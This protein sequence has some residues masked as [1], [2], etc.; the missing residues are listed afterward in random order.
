MFHPVSLFIGLRYTRAKRRNHFISFMSFTSMIGIALGVAVLITVLS[1]MN[2]FD[3]E[4]RERIFGMARQVT[5]SAYSGNLTHWQELQTTVTHY[6]GVLYEAPFVQSQGML[7]EGGLVRPVLIYGIQPSQEKNMSILADKFVA[8]NLEVLQPGKFGIVIGQKIADSLGLQV[9]DKVNLVT[10]SVSVTPMGVAPRFKRFTVVGVFKIGNGFDFDS[11]LAYLNMQDAQALFQMGDSISGLRLKINDLYE[12]P[13]LA[14]NLSRTL[15]DDYL[16]SDWTQ[17]Y[18]AFFSAIKMEKTMMFLMLLLIVA[19]AAFNL[20]SSLVMVVNDKRSDIAIL[21]TFGATP[22]TILTIFIVQGTVI[23]L[24][25]TLL[26]LIGGV[27]LA[28]NAT[29]IVSGLQHLFQV[30]L[31]A[32]DVYYVDYLPSQLLWSDVIKICCAAFIMSL[33]ATLY[34]AWDAS[35]TQPAEAL[36][37]E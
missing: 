34:P 35:R 1:V 3:H 5:V 10:P 11:S 4:I 26:G 27:A 24:V 16:V 37:Y 33:L 32:S 25:G 23:G 22:R 36:R 15:S 29:A 12:A 31:I 21:R 14:K 9:G 8:G 6:P 17:D 18:G 13:L 7:T 2:G 28:E 30:Q 19:V 20:V